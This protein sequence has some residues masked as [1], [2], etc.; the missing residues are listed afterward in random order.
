MK[1]QALLVGGFLK[2]R[3]LAESLDKK[4]YHVTIINNNFEDCLALAEMESVHV[5]NGDGTKP[6]V[7]E[8]ANAQDMDI[9]SEERRVG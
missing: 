9:R 4:G 1:K 8:D 5:I 6:F 2:T 3:S 7:L